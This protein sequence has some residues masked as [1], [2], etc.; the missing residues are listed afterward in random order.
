MHPC[1]AASAK[2][3]RLTPPWQGRQPLM[4]F[5]SVSSVLVVEVVAG[6]R[7]DLV[8][9][10]LL[11]CFLRGFLHNFLRG[12]FRCFRHDVTSFRS[13]LSCRPHRVRD[14]IKSF[15]HVL[16]H[17]RESL[18]AHLLFFRHFSS[19]KLKFFSRAIRAFPPRLTRRETANREKTSNFLRNSRIFAR[20]KREEIVTR[21]PRDRGETTR[22]IFGKF[23]KDFFLFRTR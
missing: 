6:L 15:Y 18:Q 11:G 21:Y 2:T 13:F 3:L 17:A 5:T 10:F 8:E 23:L 20:T 4:L 19:K 9:L 7:R 1:R 16:Y 14:S 22:K 12:L